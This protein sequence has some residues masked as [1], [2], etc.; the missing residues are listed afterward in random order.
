MPKKRKRFR[1]RRW[2]SMA[3]APKHSHPDDSHEFLAAVKSGGRDG[4][5]Y[6]EI[7]QWNS[8]DGGDTGPK[9][10]GAWMNRMGTEFAPMEEAIA[11]NF[12]YPYAWK[13]KPKLPPLPKEKKA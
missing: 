3:S 4:D 2:R 9:A 7:I 5:T 1:N 12:S 10:R 13:P 8:H 6:L 11:K